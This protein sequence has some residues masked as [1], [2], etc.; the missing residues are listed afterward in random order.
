MRMRRGPSKAKGLA[1]TAT[2]SASSSLAS[3]AI[4]RRRAGSRAAAQAGGDEY[5]VGALQ[6]FDD[7]VGVFK[8]GLAADLGVESVRR[9]PGDARAE[10]QLVGRQA[11]G[12]RLEVGIHGV[13]T[14]R[15]PGPS[16]YHAATR[17]CSRRRPRRSL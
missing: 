13:R 1:T 4:T 9:A 14:P 17:H 3:E 11:G 6:Q 12:E 7:F 8:R 2:V 16:R 5:H 15:L 10:L